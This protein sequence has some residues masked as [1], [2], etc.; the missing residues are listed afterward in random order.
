ML[1]YGGNAIESAGPSEPVIIIGLGSVAVAGDEFQVVED[2][3]VAS[4]TA[5]EAAVKANRERLALAG[6]DGDS[7]GRQVGEEIKEINTIIKVDASGSMYVPIAWRSLAWLRLMHH[8]SP[9]PR[10]ELRMS[11]CCRVLSPA[12]KL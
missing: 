9:P 12:G 8:F 3:K 10:S 1:D 11:S 4:S 5:E 2:S 6:A 7:S